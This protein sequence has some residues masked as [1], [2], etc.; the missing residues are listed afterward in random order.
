MLHNLI[1]LSILSIQSAIARGGKKARQYLLL[2]V[3]RITSLDRVD[4]VLPRVDPPY[5]ALGVDTRLHDD[6]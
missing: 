1:S 3:L 2:L 5:L 6:T 4:E